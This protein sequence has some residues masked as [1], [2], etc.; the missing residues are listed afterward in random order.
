VTWTSE[1]IAK[2]AQPE[3]EQLRSNAARLGR[4]EIVA[5]CDEVLVGIPKG[6]PMAAARSIKKSARVR[7][8]IAR[9]KAFEARGV[10]LHD[11][12]SSWSGLRKSDGMVVMSLWAD[13]IKLR[14]GACH[15]LLWA[16][17]LPWY[18][19]PAGRERLHHCR[20]VVEGKTAEGL[21]VYGEALAGHIP[22]DKARS[23]H[24]VDPQALVRFAVEKHGEEYWA[25]WGK[26]SI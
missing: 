4:H 22:E 10:Y 9:G 12:R 11:A 14:D 2:L 24:G 5:L 7:R 13:A 8:L 23:V 19:T 20:C 17:N 26:R 3:V 15:Y 25:V 6:K 1:R 21:L 16:P 18:D